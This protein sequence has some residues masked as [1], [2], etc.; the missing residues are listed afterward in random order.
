MYSIHYLE[1]LKTLVYCIPVFIASD[2]R[3]IAENCTVSTPESL[4]DMRFLRKQ[5]SCI[6]NVDFKFLGS[7]RLPTEARTSVVLVT[8][9]NVARNT[10]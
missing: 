7:Q 10:V 3:I 8:K 4:I 1:S 5:R 6:V 2:T 9:K